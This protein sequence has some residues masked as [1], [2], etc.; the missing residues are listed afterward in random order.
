MFRPFRNRQ[1][2]DP[3]RK[4]NSIMKKTALM[5][6][7]VAAVLF[8]CNNA[9]KERTS[10]EENVRVADSSTTAIDDHHSEN[11]LDW[12]GVYEG[13]TPCADCEGIKTV[14]ELKNDK[15]YTL[16]MT[17][18]GKENGKNEYKQQGNFR[19]DEIGSKM[20]LKTDGQPIEIKVGENKIWMLDGSGNVIEGDLAEMFILKK[21]S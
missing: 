6:M 2:Q 3:N 12:A 16:S 8:S 20:V 17:Y 14:L 7:L 19:W 10:S 15:T 5:S 11:S 21:I 4:I 9:G 13:I 18:L 1:E